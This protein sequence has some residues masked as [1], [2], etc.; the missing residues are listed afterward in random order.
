MVKDNTKSDRVH[1]APSEWKDWFE[2]MSK[3]QIYT[4]FNSQRSKKKDS[5]C[6]LAMCK[7]LWKS[8]FLLNGSNHQQDWTSPT[9][10][11]IYMKKMER[12]TVSLYGCCR[13]T[14]T[15]YRVLLGPRDYLLILHFQ[16]YTGISYLILHTLHG[17]YGICFPIREWLM[18]FW[19]SLKA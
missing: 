7:L 1:K 3:M 18:A 14:F 8:A 4:F 12:Y 19:I 13:F 17:W 2:L 6:D 11:Y 15:G 5:V 16:W 9:M 10:N